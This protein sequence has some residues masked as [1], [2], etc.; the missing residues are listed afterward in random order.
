[1]TLEEWNTKLYE[2]LYAE[3]Q[4]FVKDLQVHDSFY[5]IELAYELV[6]RE[7]L[8][9]HV[10]MNNLTPEQC[11]ALLREKKPMDKLFEAWEKHEGR[12]MEEIG[13]CVES[14]ANKLIRQH[15][16]SREAER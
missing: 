9:M 15:K 14:V 6:S 13:E 12:H 16:R 3:H 1:M 10:E 4:E 5:C 2:K 8:L 11:K 7:D